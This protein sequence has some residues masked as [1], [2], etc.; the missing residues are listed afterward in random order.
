MNLFVYDEK[1]SLLGVIEEFSSLMWIRRFSSAGAFELYAPA[2]PLNISLL[3][4]HRYI[5]R[6]DVDEAMYVSTIQEQKTDEDNTMT[7]SGY[8]IDGLFR[9]RRIPDYINYKSLIHT[10]KKCTGFGCD[11]IFHDPDNADSI[12]VTKENVK[13]CC[14]AE[15]YLRFVTK[16]I[17]CSIVGKLNIF[18]KRL[19]FT[20]KKPNDL[21]NT[22]IFSEEYDN[23]A[24]SKYE[25]SEEG[26][27]NVIFGRCN[28][29]DP[30]VELPNG[31][32]KYEVG[33]EITG[34]QANEKILYIDPVVALGVRVVF[35]GGFPTLEE[36]TYLD[37][38][39]TLKVLKEKCDSEIKKYTEN[40]SADIITSDQY[41]TVFDVGD[42]VAVQNG[43]RNIRYFKPIDEVEE[44]FDSSGYSVSPR[45]GEPLKTIYDYI[46][47]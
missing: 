9:K 42:T 47:Y 30:D 3:Q 26:C 2:T 35:I 4:P 12:T 27:A 7:V 45:F 34:L 40:F 8:S 39:V 33:T 18:E 16:K 43:L 17:G 32:P 14:N 15:E 36:Y 25:F 11:M 21:S 19:E 44:V 38:D 37:Y 1:I 20:L 5:Y 28:D 46:K 29:P 6:D 24:N 31:I 10:L 13:D 22:V 41:R 23:L